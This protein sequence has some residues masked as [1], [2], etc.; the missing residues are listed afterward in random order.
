MREDFNQ[1][2]E[3][4]FKKTEQLIFAA[5][6]RGKLDE[7]RIRELTRITSIVNR[8]FTD[9]QKLKGILMSDE[10]TGMDRVHKRIDDLEKTVSELRAVVAALKESSRFA[11]KGLD[12]TEERGYSLALKVAQIVGSLAAGGAISYGY[13]K[14]IG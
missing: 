13:I 11:E 3:D 7:Q 6:Q 2:T 9:I 10:K 12:K 1:T 5:E 14:Y 4:F 8:I